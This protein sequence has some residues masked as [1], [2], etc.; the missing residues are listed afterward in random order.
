MKFQDGRDFELAVFGEK[1]TPIENRVLK[2]ARDFS[3]E[4]L[5]VISAKGPFY[6]NTLI[7]SYLHYYISKYLRKFKVDPTGMI[8]RS[9]LN[10]SL[11]T[12]QFTDGIIFLPGVEQPLVTIDTF[13]LETDLGQLKDYWLDTFEGQFYGEEI[14]QSDLYSFK[15]GISVLSVTSSHKVLFPANFLDP[16]VNFKRPENHFVLT[17]YHVHS[18]KECRKFSRMV[19]LYFA[20]RNGSQPLRNNLEGQAKICSA[21]TIR[22]CRNFSRVLKGT[23][24]RA[25]VA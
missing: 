6:P 9:T 21:R 4:V 5:Q 24:K 8:F 17:P 12:K 11:D 25:A 22:S 20:S 23:F 10:T 18:D 15:R 13:N 1:S 19:A 16:R 3:S 7:G 14:Q 2:G